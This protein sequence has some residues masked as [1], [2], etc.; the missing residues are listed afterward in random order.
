MRSGVLLMIM[1]DGFQNKL[2]GF[3]QIVAR[4]IRLDF[5]PVVRSRVTRA[6]QNGADAGIF[7]GLEINRGVT[8]KPGLREINIQVAHG[9]I[10]QASFG[11][12][13]IAINLQLWPLARKTFRGM[14]RTKINAVEKGVFA[15]K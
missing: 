4:E 2:G 11:L 1:V 10:N 13:A 9:I 3:E 12:A 6:Q 8:D 14:M 5:V 7:G 15:S